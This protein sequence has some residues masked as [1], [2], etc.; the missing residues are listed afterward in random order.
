MAASRNTQI[1]KD[2]LELLHIHL[3]EL[4]KG[5]AEKRFS[6]KDFAARLFISP[7][8]L[9]NTIQLTTGKSPCD[10]MEEHILAGS[11][12]MLKE[13]ALS[14][15]DIGYKFAYNDPTN[16]T[17]FFKGMCGQTPLQYRKAQKEL[18]VKQ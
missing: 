11:Q 3:A 10:F 16:F 6:A 1:T 17:K 12:R 9:S 15:A 7:V 5:I 8:H 18:S 14:I 13:T 4:Q 2:F